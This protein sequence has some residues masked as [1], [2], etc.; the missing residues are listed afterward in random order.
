[1]S[2]SPKNP[3]SRQLKLLLGP[4]HRRK[5]NHIGGAQH[6]MLFYR[7]KVDLPFAARGGGEFG[8]DYF[9]DAGQGGSLRRTRPRRRKKR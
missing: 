3:S 4:C 2:E 7:A 5:R 1:M 8:F 6:F 9:G